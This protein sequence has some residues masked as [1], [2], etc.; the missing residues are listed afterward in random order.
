MPV[1][2][3]ESSRSKAPEKR[4]KLGQYQMG[5]IIGKL[6]VKSWEVILPKLRKN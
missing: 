3:G 1:K 4:E 5:N 2:D 6:G